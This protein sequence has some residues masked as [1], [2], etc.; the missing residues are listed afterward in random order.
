MKSGVDIS[1]EVGGGGVGNGG[2]C[3]G[4]VAAP[5]PAI[6]FSVGTVQ[7]QQGKQQHVESR[8]TERAERLQRP[9]SIESVASVEAG[10]D[11]S[12]EAS[13]Y[14]WRVLVRTYF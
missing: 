14:V 9:L 7:E 12:R 11:N 3:G 4:V 8:T 1:S 10:L 5:N 2:C 13:S 6:T